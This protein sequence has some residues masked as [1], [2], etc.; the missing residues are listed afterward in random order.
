MQSIIHIGTNLLSLTA[1]IYFFYFFV[2][3]FFTFQFDLKD[4]IAKSNLLSVL[5]DLQNKD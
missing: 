5:Y 3:L 4:D 1:E 2:F